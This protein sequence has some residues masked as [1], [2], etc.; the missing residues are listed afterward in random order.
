MIRAQAVFI[1]IFALGLAGCGRNDPAS[2]T[3]AFIDASNRGDKE[4]AEALLTRLARENVKSGKGEGVSITK[5]DPVT[6]KNRKWDDYSV[7]AAVIDG[8][9]ATVPVTTKSNEKSET[10]KFKLRREDGAWK[11]FGFAFPIDANGQEIVLDL[12]HPERFA[13]ELL[14]ALPQA[15]GE[16]LKK[17]GDALSKAGNDISNSLQKR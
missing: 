10:M 4:S 16:G 2:V 7:G 6:S 8:E 17:L 1:C 15:L 12:E 3:K 9:N 13:G 11:V 5:K 14:K